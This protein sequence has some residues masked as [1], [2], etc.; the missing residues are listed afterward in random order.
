MAMRSAQGG[1]S[2]QITRNGGYVALESADGKLLYYTKTGAYSGARLYALGLPGGG[3]EREVLSDIA[4]RG[5]VVL[6]DGI[7]YLTTTGAQTTDIRFYDFATRRDSV[8]ANVQGSLG[9]GLS[10]SPDRKTILFSGWVTW[11]TDL[12]LIDYFR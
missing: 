2:E 7:Y 4:G 8:V 5:F 1:A 3:E 12:M 9:L 11:G 10:V 6:Q